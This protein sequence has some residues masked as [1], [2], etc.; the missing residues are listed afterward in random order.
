MRIGIIGAGFGGLAAA[1]DFINAG[2]QVTVLEGSD[3]VGGLA[4][5]FKEPHWDWSVEQFYH[6]WFASDAAMLGLIQIGRA[7]V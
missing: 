2:H 7:H 6:H 5:G 4:A 1:H 3:H